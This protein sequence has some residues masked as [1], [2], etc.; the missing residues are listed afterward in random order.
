[1]GELRPS[2]VDDMMTDEETSRA[3]EAMARFEAALEDIVLEAFARGGKIEGTWRIEPPVT[4][5]PNWLVTVTKV[6]P[7]G[8]A[9]YEPSLIDE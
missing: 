7:T 1:M 2:L 6:D 5:A 8:E 4:D 9:R 3:G